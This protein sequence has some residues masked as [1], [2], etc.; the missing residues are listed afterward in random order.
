MPI[1]LA[2]GEEKR[3]IDFTLAA[4]RAALSESGL[5]PNDIDLLVFVG[6]GRGFVEPATA[7]ILQSAL[8]L[9]R[10]T[11]FDVLDACASWLRGVEIAH[12]Y[13]RAGRSRHAMIVN[14]EF[15]FQEY[16]RLEFES[17]EALDR[18]WAGL[19]I[20]EA[21]PA[22]IVS[23]DDAATFYS[24]FATSG[25]YSD[26]C[27]IPLPHARQFM[28]PDYRDGHHALRF[29]SDSRRLHFHGIQLLATPFL[30]D[31]EARR[32][33]TISFSA[34]GG[35]SCVAGGGGPSSWT[36]GATS[37]SFGMWHTVSGVA[38][39][40]DVAGTRCRTPQARRRVFLSGER[41]HHHRL[42]HATSEER[43]TACSPCFAS[44]RAGAGD[45]ILSFPLH[46]AWSL[47]RSPCIRV[48]VTLASI[49]R[50]GRRR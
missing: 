45:G 50:P 1:E 27:S 4:A 23:A 8:G 24:R 48:R 19:T 43:A 41:R 30:A 20:G 28:T 46:L 39:A 11:C 36:S 3:A 18:D 2:E 32:F 35:R 40:G 16:V 26:L 49:I 14:C 5:S 25:D 44:R 22:T 10:A 21:A 29:H 12:M 34:R 7:G 37:K 15:N 42:R 6:V 33:H 38:A 31:Q 47:R 9:A 13:I 17:P